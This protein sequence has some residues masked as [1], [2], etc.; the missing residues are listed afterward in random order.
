MLPAVK[1]IL[2]FLAVMPNLSPFLVINILETRVSDN[3]SFN[4]IRSASSCDI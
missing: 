3:F 2:E 1:M 4:R